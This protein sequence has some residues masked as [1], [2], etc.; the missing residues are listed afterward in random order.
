MIYKVLKNKLAVFFV[1]IFC[2]CCLINIKLNFSPMEGRSI[3]DLVI[4]FHNYFLQTFSLTEKDKLDKALADYYNNL[5]ASGKDSTKF[6]IDFAEIVPFEWDTVCYFRYST[7]YDHYPQELKDYAK[8]HNIQRDCESLHFLKGKNVV[9]SV[10]LELYSEKERGVL[11]CTNKKI[12]KRARG[13]AKFYVR[14][15]EQFYIVKDMTEE[16]IYNWRYIDEKRHDE[17]Q[18]NLRERNKGKIDRK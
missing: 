9:Y 6:V 11:F 8:E 15:L 16:F 5:K 13:D 10:N 7:T 14:K 18:K 17:I 2:F 12:I 4:E 1:L 3:W